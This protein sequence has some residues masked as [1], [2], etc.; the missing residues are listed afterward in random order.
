MIDVP[1]LDNPLEAGYMRCCGN[2]YNP[3]L[4]DAKEYRYIEE[5]L[6]QDFH[7]V[8]LKDK[9]IS[10]PMADTKEQAEK[11][12]RNGLVSVWGKGTGLDEPFATDILK[13]YL[14]EQPVRFR[15]LYLEDDNGNAT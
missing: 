1:F 10:Y 8:W 13:E 6:G 15:A 11:H 5:T 3:R 4:P 12:M 7:E 2:T 14:V 9:V